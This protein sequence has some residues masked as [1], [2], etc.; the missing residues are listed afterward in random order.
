MGVILKYFP[1]KGC[2]SKVRTVPR[3][4]FFLI[5]VWLLTACGSGGP[6][7]FS[8]QGLGAN[9]VSGTVRYEKKLYNQDGF[10]GQRVFL[11]VRSVPI[12]VWSSQTLL[13]RTTT[14]DQGHYCAIYVNSSGPTLNSVV[15]TA[16][17]LTTSKVQVG[18]FFQDPNDDLFH[19][20]PWWVEAN[21]D[22]RQGTSFSIN[23]DL[24]DNVADPTL[25]PGG[26]FN[27]LDT[28]RKGREVFKSMTG[29]EPPPLTVIWDRT[30]GG[31]FFTTMEDCRQMVVGGAQGIFSDCLFIRGDGEIFIDEV[32]G[33]DR[34]EYDDDIILHEYG[35]FIANNFSKDDSR[36][37]AHYLNDYTQDVRLAWSEGWA[38]FFSSVVRNNALQV[39]VGVDGTA[40]FAFSIDSKSPFFFNSSSIF[41]TNEV[42][43]SSVLWDIFDQI[44][45][46]TNDYLSLGFGPIWDTLTF[47]RSTPPSSLI[48]MEAFW[49]SFGEVQPAFLNITRERQM[50]FLKD[51]FENDNTPLT[52][53]LA[54]PGTSEHHTLFPEGDVDYIAFN[55]VMSQSYTAETLNLKNGVD[56]FLEIVDATGNVLASNDNTDGRVY[57]DGCNTWETV[58]VKFDSNGKCIDQRLQP[59][60]DPSC[61]NGQ[62]VLVGVLR[63]GVNDKDPFPSRIIFSAPATG[64]FY[65]RV[66]RSPK[67]PP[68][69][70]RYGSYDFRVTQVISP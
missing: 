17:N 23:F 22:E 18:S 15:V 3:S 68:S 21:F 12:E 53:R 6:A 13:A 58:C 54:T 24:R 32:L 11:P 10:T 37:G 65:A 62:V 67:A 36:G 16:S 5:G 51:G 33:G 9:T 69:T 38:T 48:T 42:A 25:N 1:S 47:W 41:T 70:G 2:I 35:H 43:V 63:D 44:D 39:D 40:Q 30:L 28:V 7:D 61:P 55:G 64:T 52:S 34:D 20:I 66:S 59:R 60:V 27:I 46:N 50:E 4:P 8:C 57:Q 14:D 49:N 56:T 31:T 26:V 19:F 45:P 29:K